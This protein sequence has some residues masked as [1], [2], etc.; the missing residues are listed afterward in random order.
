MSPQTWGLRPSPLK[1]IKAWSAMSYQA[2]LFVCS[3]L[4]R[5][6]S[7]GRVFGCLIGKCEIT[8]RQGRATRWYSIT[9]KS[10]ARGRAALLIVHGAS[11]EIVRYVE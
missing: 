2:V 11:I 3:N 6:I 4:L 8:A 1:W 9:R 10:L 7:K 5:H